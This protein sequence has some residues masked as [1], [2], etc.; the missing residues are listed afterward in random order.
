MRQMSAGAGTEDPARLR[1]LNA[2]NNTGW[3]ALKQEVQTRVQPEHVLA[4]LSK[5]ILQTQQQK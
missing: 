1:E 3:L 2:S 5:T 4:F